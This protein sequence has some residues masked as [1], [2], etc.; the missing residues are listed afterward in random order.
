MRKKTLKAIAL[1]TMAGM[2][3]QFGGCLNLDQLLRQAVVHTAIDFVT[4]NNTVIGLFTG[5]GA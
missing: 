2:L 1:T 3:F 4:G 5:T